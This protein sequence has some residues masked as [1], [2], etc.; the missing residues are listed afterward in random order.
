MLSQPLSP[1]AMIPDHNNNSND[2]LENIRQEDL[3]RHLVKRCLLQAQV[4]TSQWSQHEPDLL[5]LSKTIL[6][7]YPS[8]SSSSFSPLIICL[9]R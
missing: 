9:G 3:L 7:S 1:R 5:R 8:P 4:P 6:S 2:S